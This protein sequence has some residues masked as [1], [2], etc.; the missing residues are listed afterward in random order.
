MVPNGGLK[1]ELS[2][3]RV[4]RSTAELPRFIV[5]GSNGSCKNITSSTSR[6]SSLF[7]YQIVVFVPT[8]SVAQCVVTYLD[9]G[10][11]FHEE[12]DKVKK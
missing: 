2:R 4:R 5:G 1:P 8:S 3:F 12:R 9:V 6:F 10:G 7:Y 11:L